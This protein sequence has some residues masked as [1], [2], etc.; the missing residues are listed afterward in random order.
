MTSKTE[1]DKVNDERHIENLR[2]FDNIDTDL[3]KNT[4]IGQ[5]A[6]RECQSNRHDIKGLT[7][8]IKDWIDHLQEEREDQK[9]INTEFAQKIEKLTYRLMWISGGIAVIGVLAHELGDLLS[10]VLRTLLGVPMK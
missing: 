9:K 2:K 1:S 6:L 4:E 5:Q 3:R 7:A 10:P 8:S